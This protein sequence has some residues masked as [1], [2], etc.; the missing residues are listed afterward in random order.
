MVAA[1]GDRERMPEP[2]RVMISHGTVSVVKTPS[3]ARGFAAV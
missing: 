3:S 1:W 2:W